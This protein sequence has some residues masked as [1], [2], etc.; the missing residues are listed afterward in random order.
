MEVYRG[1]VYGL[2]E[3]ELPDDTKLTQA[4]RDHLVLLDPEDQVLDCYPFY[5]LLANEDTRY[6]THMCFFKQRK[7]GE[8]LLEG[9]SVQGAFGINLEGFN[10]LDTLLRLADKS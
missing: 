9:E 5:Q 4:D 2:D 1:P 6:E 3:Q 10:E 7:A 8:S